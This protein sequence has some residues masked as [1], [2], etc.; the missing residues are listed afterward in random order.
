MRLRNR[1]GLLTL[2]QVEHNLD[3]VDAVADQV[4]LPVVDLTVTAGPD[5]ASPRRRGQPLRGQQV[6]MHPHDQHFLIAAG[7]AAAVSLELPGLAV[8][9]SVLAIAAGAAQGED[10]VTGFEDKLIGAELGPDRG[11]QLLQQPAGS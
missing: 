9:I 5:A 3:D 2:R 7:F 4:A 6:W 8:P 11:E 1:F 10:R